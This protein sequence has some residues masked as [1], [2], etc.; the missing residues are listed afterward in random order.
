MAEV[1]TLSVEEVAAGCREESQRL[2]AETGFCYEL[3]RRAL[4]EGSQPAWAAIERQYRRLLCAWIAA[5]A[6]DLP[7][8]Q[9]EEQA[10]ETLERFWRS[11]A[12]RRPDAAGQFAH[13]GALL[14][15]L[16]QCAVSTLLDRRRR[17]SR[18]ER[19]RERLAQ[20]QRA[21]GP[22]DPSDLALARLAQREQ[23]ARVR[24][25]LAA[26]V[27]DPAERLV[28]ELSFRLDLSPAE[29]AARHP[30][31][32]GDAQSVRRIKERVLKRARRA[33]EGGAPQ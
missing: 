24:A 4:D 21:E 18:L 11:L 19:L 17:A 7:P 3:F 10:H 29:I 12:P 5:R 30:E 32:F 31:Q 13:I 16:Q 2:G 26:E 33:L 28:L 25:W 22:P 27:A 14:R 20:E 1:E 6:P 23:L 15:Y 8:D 9:V